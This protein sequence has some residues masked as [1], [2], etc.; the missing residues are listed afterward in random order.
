MTGKMKKTGSS[1]GTFDSTRGINKSYYGVRTFFL[2]DLP[3][4]RRLGLT[5]DGETKVIIQPQDFANIPYFDL[6]K[7]TSTKGVWSE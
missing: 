4:I 5:I 3:I 2:L 7:A 1:S 6:G